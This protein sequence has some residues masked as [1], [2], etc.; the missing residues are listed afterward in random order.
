M[1]A[2]AVLVGSTP[3]RAADGPPLAQ[4]LSLADAL[5]AVEERNLTLAAA[6]SEIDKADAQL[7]S[8]WAHL[9]PALA[10]QLGYTHNDHD[11]TFNPTTSLAPLLSRMGIPVPDDGDLIVRRQDEL[12]GGVTVSL[13]IVAPQAW[14]GVSA[15]RHGVEVARLSVEGIRDRLLLATAQAYWVAVVNRE[16]VD[17]R[18]NHVHSSSEHRDLAKARLDAGDGLRIDVIRAET[19]LESARQ[20]LLAARLALDNARDALGTLTGLG[21]LPMPAEPPALEPPEVSAGALEALT[22][23]RADVRAAQAGVALADRLVDVAWMQ[24]LPALGVGAQ[25]GYLLSE[26]PDLGSSDRSRWAALITLTV[27]LYSQS[28]YADLEARRAALR[29]AQARADD[30]RRNAGLEA[31]KARRDYLSAVASS[32]IAEHQA[33]LARE[34]LA[35]VESAYANGASTSLDVS[36]AQRALRNA[37]LRHAAQRLRSQVALLRLLHAVGQDLRPLGSRPR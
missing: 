34:G 5:Q 2:G 9:A 33:T 16:L 11:D 20:D 27:P 12:R 35:L 10:G 32:Q 26:P 31:R 36:D 1:V 21:G 13:P 24:F 8:A 25:V 22:A 23:Q 7:S 37:E 17:I 6:A 3:A 28:R 4:E 14:M 29:Q 30:A 19:E 15:A 18:E